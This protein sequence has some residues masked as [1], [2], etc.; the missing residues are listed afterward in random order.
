MYAQ[1]I[2]NKQTKNPLLLRININSQQQDDSL[3]S[4]IDELCSIPD[5]EFYKKKEKPGMCL[6]RGMRREAEE[7]KRAKAGVDEKR[8]R[9]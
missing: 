9:E 4:K 8:A 1:K 5:A 6:A 2:K 7:G 3:A